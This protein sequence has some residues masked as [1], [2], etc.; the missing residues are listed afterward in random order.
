MDYKFNPRQLISLVSFLI[1]RRISRRAVYYVKSHSSG[2][3]FLT[4]QAMRRGVFL[5]HY[6]LQLNEHFREYV[7]ALFF[8]YF[9]NRR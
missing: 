3:I 7:V 5:I 2:W 9:C 1:E 8:F 6:D 4:P